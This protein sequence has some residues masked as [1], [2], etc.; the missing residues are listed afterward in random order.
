MTVCRRKRCERC[1]KQ[2]ILLLRCCKFSCF[3]DFVFMEQIQISSQVRVAQFT[4]GLQ[5]ESNST[6]QHHARHTCRGRKH[7]LSAHRG[8]DI[9]RKR[10]MGWGAAWQRLGELSGGGGKS[11]RRKASLSV[12]A[13]VK[14]NSPLPVE[15][16]ETDS[17]IL[18]RLYHEL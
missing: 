11:E 18:H 16:S 17:F 13:Y 2:R 4:A 8:P 5:S 7:T 3:N 9:K 15:A 12:S 6:K 10:W 1:H 14:S